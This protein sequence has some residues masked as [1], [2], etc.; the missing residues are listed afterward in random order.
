MNDEAFAALEAVS[1]SGRIDSA[2][3][4]HWIQAFKTVRWV[5]Q[6]GTGLAL[7]PAGQKARDEMA[8]QKRG[9]ARSDDRGAQPASGMAAPAK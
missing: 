9:A 4:Q 5:V 6:T 1:R 7:T 3:H 2:E 8:A